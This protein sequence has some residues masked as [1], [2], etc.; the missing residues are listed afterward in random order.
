MS[1]VRVPLGP[2]EVRRPSR[3]LPV[4]EL[5]DDGLDAV[6]AAREHRDPVPVVRQGAGGGGTDPGR[7]AGDDRDAPGGGR[8]AQGALL[9]S[10]ERRGGEEGGGGGGSGAWRWEGVRIG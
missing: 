5:L 6:E 4:A 10:E 7:C 1:G 8:G 9:R 2:P 3:A